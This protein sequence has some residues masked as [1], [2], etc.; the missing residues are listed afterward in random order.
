[1]TCDSEI[2]LFY[3]GYTTFTCQMSYSITNIL[4]ASLKQSN[5][6]Q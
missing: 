4:C 6:K 1:M 2:N 3:V 5:K